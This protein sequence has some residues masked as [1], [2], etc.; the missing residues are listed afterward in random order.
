MPANRFDTLAAA[1]TAAARLT[2]ETGEQ[3]IAYESSYAFDRFVV[4]RLPQ[5]GDEVSKGFNGDYYPCGKIDR[6]SETYSWIATE[7]GDVFARV[8]PACWKQGGKRGAFSLVQ[9]HHNERNPHF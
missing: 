6:I 1:E 3:H 8:G 5:V 7:D 4:A 2:E 9:G